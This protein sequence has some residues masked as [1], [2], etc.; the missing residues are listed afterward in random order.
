MPDHCDHTMSG[1]H[2]YDVREAETR[3][4]FVGCLCGRRPTSDEIAGNEVLRE[5]Q[6]EIFSSGLSGLPGKA[7]ID[8]AIANLDD[9]IDDARG[10]VSQLEEVAGV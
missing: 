8:R 1:L 2:V 4:P 6:R 10:I 5:M 7:D 3:N 9:A